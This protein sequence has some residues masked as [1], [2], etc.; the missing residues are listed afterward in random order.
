MPGPLKW[1]AEHQPVS[2]VIDAVRSLTYGG[3]FARSRQGGGRDH[4]GASAIIAVARRSPC[5]SI[6][7]RC[8]R[9]L[10]AARAAEP[11]KRTDAAVVRRPRAASASRRVRPRL[12]SATSNAEVQRRR[13]R[14]SSVGFSTRTMMPSPSSAGLHARED[15]TRRR[16][17]RAAKLPSASSGSGPPITPRRPISAAGASA[18]AAASVIVAAIRPEHLRAG[19][20]HLGPRG[21]RTGPQLDAGQRADTAHERDEDLAVRRDLGFGQSRARRRRVRW[22]RSS[23][24][25]RTSAARD[26][27]TAASSGGAV[28]RVAASNVVAASNAVDGRAGGEA[29]PKAMIGRAVVERDLAAHERHAGRE[30]RVDNERA[31][32][33][34]SRG[35]R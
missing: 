4:R 21:H 13:R 15:A 32:R 31:D 22:R 35:S 10:T 25:A 9:A 6:A 5:G 12:A 20:E 26:A 8:E 17:A 1:F 16:R 28:V 30:R 11:A 3:P 23:P 14:A 2:I 18:G 24:G 7:A 33:R 19:R 27:P 29:E 34:R